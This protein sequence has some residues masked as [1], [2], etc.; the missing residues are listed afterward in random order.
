MHIVSSDEHRRA[1]LLRVAAQD[2]AAIAPSTH[3]FDE[4]V[5]GLHRALL[6]H[7]SLAHPLVERI[8]AAVA[9]SRVR[10]GEGYVRATALASA[11]DVLR[12]DAI[13]SDV[14]SRALD[15]VDPAEEGAR[16][17]LSALTEA[18]RAVDE[19][20]EAEGLFA[21]SAIEAALA[22][23]LD[24]L[25]PHESLPPPVGPS[26]REVYVSLAGASLDL[27]RAQL[28][29]A[30][31]R[32][33]SRRG[34][35]L[36]LQ[37]YVEPVR[38]RWSAS[39]DRAL[40][41]FED[42]DQSMVELE[43]SLRARSEPR[44]APELEA[45][46]RAMAAGGRSSDA[47]VRL[48]EA[49]GPDE[50]ARWAV[51]V[52]EQWLDDGI[53]ARDI[54]VV[55]RSGERE[56]VEPVLRA[57]D[58]AGVRARLDRACVRGIERPGVASALVALARALAEGGDVERVTFALSALAGPRALRG[59]P[60]TALA[61]AARAVRARTVFDKK[62]DVLG[63]HVSPATAD[64]ASTLRA[65]VAPLA[66]EGSVEDHCK[67]WL[68]FLRGIDAAARHA[69][70]ARSLGA[71]ALGDEPSSRALLRSSSREE[72]AMD[73]IERAL[74]Q[75]G[76]R[77]RRAGL[78]APLDAASFAALLEDAIELG[79]EASSLD[80]EACAG[81]VFVVTAEAVAG[82][83]FR[84]VVVVGVEDGRFPAH[85]E[86]NSLLGEVE[87]R[88]VQRT[89][90]VLV[91]RRGAK[92]D[93]AQ[94]FLA[95]CAT[96]SERLALVGAR[97]DAGGRALAP[98]PFMLD[99]RRALDRGPEWITHDPLAR[100][101]V[102]LARGSER[103]A[104]AWSG[105]PSRVEVAKLLAGHEAPHSDA[106]ASHALADRVRSVIER[107][108]IERER[109]DFFAGVRAEPG[110]FSGR[111]DHDPRA[112]EAL[113]LHRYATTTWPLDVTSL[114][115][116]ARCAFKAFAQQVL[117]LEP[118]DVPSLA[119]D[120]KERGHLLHALVEAGQRALHGTQGRPRAERWSKVVEAMDEAA[121]RFGAELPHADPDLL[122]ADTLAIR[123]MIEGY[124]E[125][126]MDADTRWSVVATE[127]AFGPERE[128]PALEVAVDDAA[129]IVLRGRIDGVERL[130]ESVRA[131]EFKSG[132]GDGFRK[133]LRDGCL[134]TQFQLIVYAAALYRAVR[135]GRVDATGVDIDGVY[136]GFRDQSEHTLREVLA[137]P[138]RG[139]GE[140]PVADV[141][142]LVREG[143]HGRGPLGEA[144]RRAVLPVR[145]GVF[146]PQPRD[147]EFC[148]AQSLCR[149]EKGR[150]ARGA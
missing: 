141:D 43:L 70:V 97:H 82:L 132:R 87:R 41:V 99:A 140:P 80:R 129:P 112:I 59:L 130:D 25:E 69:E 127:V 66:S 35:A 115:R 146:A 2:G 39:L 38:E 37:V 34:G 75:L 123:R 92:E 90:G 58:E 85:T 122:R 16:R 26:A 125:G 98:S 109:S 61:H 120:A 20:L 68:A 145:Q 60:P 48:A 138:R 79:G 42:D 50:S 124:L 18:A 106:R 62:L 89:T 11:L 94:L 71:V 27:S 64:A 10:G 113:E 23:A 53:D 118:E 47:P 150:E 52:V 111:I 72:R 108:N 105:W 102:V 74:E 73:A 46:V 55:L 4:L 28:L 22:R 51:A 36:S 8:A 107:A 126:K 148:N 114:E 128:W 131:V 84:A 78:R 83:S 15:A 44:C 95:A 117:K 119:L 134:D 142:A 93:E 121:E 33:L 76:P 24:A 81:G 12:R 133:R 9:A 29:A 17:R 13:D 65:L 101:S 110:R 86:E 7:V 91:A 67:R 45:F 139:G 147:C 21:R 100:S 104:R 14:L 63:R 3:T 143:A 137:Q 96:A 6:P 149:V 49:H 77:A 103:L 116:T 32:A 30:L 88:A 56:E 57:L 31:A 1:R 135:D 144:V 19:R 40:R 54:A 5:R 136:V